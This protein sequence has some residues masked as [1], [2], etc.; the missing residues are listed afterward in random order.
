VSGSYER[1][2]QRND[3]IIRLQLFV[4]VVL[5]LIRKNNL[6]VDTFEDT[7]LLINTASAETLFS[8]PFQANPLNR[9]FYHAM[10][11]FYYVSV[12]SDV[13]AFSSL[14][15]SA[16]ISFERGVERSVLYFELYALLTETSFYLLN[17]GALTSSDRAAVDTIFQDAVKKL[18]KY[19]KVFRLAQ[20][21][22]H[23][24][25][26][27]RQDHAGKSDQAHESWKRSLA[28]ATAL[29]MPYE[30]GLAHATLARC[31]GIPEDERLKHLHE[32][33]QLFERMG[34]AY[35]LA[36]LNRTSI[37]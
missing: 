31:D 36:V 32:A 10:R 20:P 25:E 28:S 19:G 26:G 6:S 30:A 3:R 2:K 7:A 17:S 16:R 18:T 14:Q 1:A 27:W 22:A 5:L 13:Q 29:Q 23:L 37:K 11:A 9:G 35:D 12:S 34:A 33:R 15:E 4:M 24:Y 8:E 21:R